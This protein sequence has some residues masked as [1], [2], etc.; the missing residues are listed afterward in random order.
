[1]NS[2]IRHGSPF[3]KQRPL[4]IHSLVHDPLAVKRRRK[5]SWRFDVVLWVDLQV[6][7]SDWCRCYGAW[8][9]TNDSYNQTLAHC[10]VFIVSTLTLHYPMK[11]GV[12][13]ISIPPKKW[14]EDQGTSFYIGV[15]LNSLICKGPFFA[16]KDSTFPKPSLFFCYDS[17]LDLILPFE[18]VTDT[19]TM[20]WTISSN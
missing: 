16:D 15:D 7:R 18:R 19:K 2:I 14:S 20:W 9:I 4:N 12:P 1:M 13:K 3:T 5:T 17:P 11:M 10:C 6:S 8:L